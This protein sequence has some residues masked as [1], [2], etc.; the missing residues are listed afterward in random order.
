MFDVVVVGGGSAGAMAA[1]ASARNGAK[2]CL[3]EEKS[4][5][6]G[7]NTASLVGP[8]VPFIGEDKQPIVGGIP[9]ELINRLIK[10]G[11]AIGHV[12]DP[13]DFAYGLTPVDFSLMQLELIQMANEAKVEMYLNHSVVDVSKKQTNIISVVVSDLNGQRFEIKGKQYIDAT[14]DADV[15][16]LAGCE[17]FVG[18]KSDHK[19]QPMTM[20]FNLS[21]V[22]LE[23]VRDDVMKNPDNFV[24]SEEIRQGKRMDYVAI[25]GYFDEVSKSSN[26][27]IERDRLLFFQGVTKNDVGMNTTRILDKTSLNTQSLSEAEIIGQDQVTKLFA[28]LKENIEAFKDATIKNIGSVGVRE[29]RHLVGKKTLTELN[30]LRGD[31]QE[32]SIAV[33]CYPIDIHAPDSSLMEYVEDQTLKNFEIDLEMLQSDE[34]NNLLV[35]GRPISATHQAHAASRVSVTCMAIGQSAGLIA[36]LSSQEDIA[37]DQLPY[38]KIKE[39][40]TQHG[41]IVER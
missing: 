36:S 7:T 20:C 4:I 22:N 35:V 12:D 41:G 13:I 31:K 9:Q 24:V 30:V 34:V 8:L 18:R 19:S 29:S 27:P 2:T 1:I 14:G 28:W 26:F 17:L 16:M 6:G 38:K 11:G 23:M 39:L 25:S 5:L 10:K 21:N 37:I 32:R 33:G 15:A 40:I 3:I